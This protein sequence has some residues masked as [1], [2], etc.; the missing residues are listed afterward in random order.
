MYCNTRFFPQKAALWNQL[1]DGELWLLCLQSSS[2]LF[3]IQLLEIKSPLSI[4][5]NFHW[6]VKPD[7]VSLLWIWMLLDKLFNSSILLSSFINRAICLRLLDRHL[8]KI[9]NDQETSSAM[10][11]SII[12]KENQKQE[13]MIKKQSG[14]YWEWG[15]RMGSTE[16]RLP[17]A[18]VGWVT[19][20]ARNPRPEAKADTCA[21]AWTWGMC[22]VPVTVMSGPCCSEVKW[23]RW[24]R[25]WKAML[26]LRWVISKV[27]SSHGNDFLSIVLKLQTPWG[28]NKHIYVSMT[29]EYSFWGELEQCCIR[30]LE[31]GMSL[32]IYFKW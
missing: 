5:K 7:L 17:R 29:C 1:G 14:W 19:E 4:Q 27:C 15:L 22:C 10:V 8:W 25:P 32:H 18:H 28:P 9:K 13:P 6:W 2:I 24:F 30:E 31:Q 12:S 16:E 26:S 23:E 21:E 3:V 11:E 20:V